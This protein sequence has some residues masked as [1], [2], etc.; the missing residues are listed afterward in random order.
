MNYEN[1]ILYYFKKD[2]LKIIFTDLILILKSNKMIW[3]ILNK[4]I[5]NQTL[6]KD[7]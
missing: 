1:R 4:L 7:F 2:H 5:R 3:I 6:K